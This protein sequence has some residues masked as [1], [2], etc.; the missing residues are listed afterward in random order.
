MSAG[1]SRPLQNP[2]KRRARARDGARP[3]TD[4]DV[5]AKL[6]GQLTRVELQLGDGRYLLAYAY[7]RKPAD[8]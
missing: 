3:V 8:A 2:A 7:S 6:P 1:M 5:A 4:D